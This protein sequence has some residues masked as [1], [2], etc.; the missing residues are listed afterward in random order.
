MQSAS[1]PP[2]LQVRVTEVQYRFQGSCKGMPR[3]Y[4]YPQQMGLKAICAVKTAPIL[5]EC[6]CLI[7]AWRCETD[8]VWS[9]II[10]HCSFP[11]DLL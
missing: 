7:S 5:I 8:N 1:R 2:G 9:M 10:Q 11:T 4:R 3:Q 6:A